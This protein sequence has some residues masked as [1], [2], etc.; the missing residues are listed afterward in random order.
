M[1]NIELLLSAGSVTI[2][3]WSLIVAKRTAKA[4][5]RVAQREDARERRN[6]NAT[7]LQK[8]SELLIE[9]RAQTKAAKLEIRDSADEAFKQLQWLVDDI[10]SAKPPRQS[11]HLFHQLS[12]GISD[13]FAPEFGYQYEQNLLWRFAGVRR[14]LRELSESC[15]ART[16][17]ADEAPGMTAW[18]AAL[19]NWLPGTSSQLRPSA[20]RQLLLSESFTGLFG[21]L[22]SRLDADAG[23]RLLRASLDPIESFCELQRRI[24]PTLDAARDRLQDALDRNLAEEFKLSESATLHAQLE[25]EMR[26]LGLLSGLSLADMKHFR[27]HD[28]VDAVPEL[29]HS[30]AVLYSLSRVADRSA[31]SSVPMTC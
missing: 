31:Y 30:G 7:H 15:A 3:L 13:A 9:V 27:Q 2:A 25:W 20:E 24:R 26:A 12:E 11:R 23:R 28:V 21:E 22:N 19:S 4:Q 17:Q 18:V 10:A 6:A 5:E 29:I 16:S 8:Y 1:E 14:M